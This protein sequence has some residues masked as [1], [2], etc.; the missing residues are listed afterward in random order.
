MLS[1]MEASIMRPLPRRSSVRKATPLS[2]ASRGASGESVSSPTRTSP[3][4]H[5]AI[6]DAVMQRDARA[7][8]LTMRAHIMAA[9]SR[10]GYDV[11]PD[12]IELSLL[13]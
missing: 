13:G 9:A 6:Y 1:E 10:L 8:A 2:I 12:S 4:E 5:S 7:A 3:S 11:S